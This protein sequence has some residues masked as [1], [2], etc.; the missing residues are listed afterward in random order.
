MRNNISY[1]F[2]LFLLF[3]S[4]NLSLN[5]QEL[6]INSAKIKYDNINKITILEGNVKTEDDKGN[7]LFS[8]YASFNKLDDVIKTKGKT[9]IVTSAGYEVMSANVVFDNK[10]KIIY[11]NNKTRIKDKDG[12][13]IFVDMFNYSILTNIF[14]SKGNIEVSDID[15]NNYKFSE[16]YIDENKKKIIGS[17]VK[18][19]LKQSDILNNANNEPR[20]FANTMSL[21]NNVNTLEK[22]VFTYCKN[23]G[24]DKCPPWTLQAQKINHDLAKKTIYYDNVILKIYDFPIFFAP[25][26]SHPDPTVKRRSGI[27]APT[28]TNSS[29]LGSGFQTS[30]FWDIAND[31]D[32]TFNPKFYARENPLMLA[33]YRQDFKKSFLTVDAGYTK[34]Y[35]KTT[36]K[37]S[38]GG[39]SHFFA[40]FK[41]NLINTLDKSSSLEVNIE[42]TSNDTYLKIY[43]VDTLLVDSDQKILENS[44]NYT[45]Q[46]NDYY[47]SLSPSI[48][49][50]INKKG[51]LRHEYLLPLTIEKNII[52]SEKFGYVDLNT[53]VKIRN[54]DTNKE[55]N[56]LVNT[57]DWV[58]N[59]SLNKFG[60]ENFLNAKMKVVNYDANNTDEYK[61]NKTNSELHSV[62][63]Y[64]AKLG[65]YKND[66]INK[67]IQT[68]T[69]K[70]LLRYAP[71]HMRSIKTGRLKYENL[72]SLNKFNELDVIESG[73][74]SS[75]GFE[76]KK[77]KLNDDN[78][79]GDNVMSFS[80]G[81]VISSEENMDIPASSSLDQK[82]SDLVGVADF[83]INKKIDLNY[84]FSIDQNYNNFN[85]NEIG[86]DLSFEEVKFNVSYLQE[87]NHIGNAE[88]IKSE[89]DYKL[90]NFGEL[91]FS[92]K[93]N[94]LTS[95]AEFYNLSY[96]Y[97]NDCLKAGVAYR[98]EFYTDR[99]IEPANT[100]M[101][102]ISI[103]PF[104]EISTPGKAK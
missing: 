62:L 19:F 49:E 10:K 24:D 90:N 87:K 40:N 21:S 36:N 102:T 56:F 80:V 22:G 11:S 101:F 77:N 28:L 8:D 5:A 55:T 74:S 25:K 99:D 91:S 48:Y 64:I 93:R 82:F 1:N 59:K 103:I 63:G 50:D 39:R 66:L 32:I 97:L 60:F 43:D 95:S 78:K 9:K 4:F 73:L 45:Y 3:L 75:V 42:K 33:E 65:F 96:T 16:I 14:F 34:G 26:F 86:A 15:N 88:Y 89:V 104:G 12:N 83:N 100:L 30:Y 71:G 72:Y 52:T 44:V 92:T 76:Y 38:A 61:N 37:K 41:K 67:S 18:A 68:I 79:I 13:K 31:R 46:K 6:K 20:I 85:Y 35:K 17:D 29:T 94:L 70:L 57:F 58:S 81:Q 7:T 51:N 27:L 54:Y 23:R 53:N 98:R 2:F 84:N 69:P 47:F